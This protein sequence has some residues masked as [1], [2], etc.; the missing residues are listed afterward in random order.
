MGRVEQSDIQQMYPPTAATKT[1][2][3][4]ETLNV[5]LELHPFHRPTDMHTPTQM[6]VMGRALSH[7]TG[8]ST[9]SEKNRSNSVDERETARLRERHDNQ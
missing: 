6:A 7:I 1:P 8:E 3:G 4:V 2:L 9:S 5:N